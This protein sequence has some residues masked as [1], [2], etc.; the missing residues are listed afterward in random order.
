M[1]EMTYHSELLFAL[2]TVLETSNWRS[3]GLVRVFDKGGV[4]ILVVVVILVVIFRLLCFGFGLCFQLYLSG[5]GKLPLLW[6]RGFL[7]FVQFVRVVSVG[8][9][10]QRLV[11]EKIG[12]KGFD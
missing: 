10:Q 8:R 7:W 1:L 5:F 6:F 2:C 12:R 4:G 3:D 9:L 11:D